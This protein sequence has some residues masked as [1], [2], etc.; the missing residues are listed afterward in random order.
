MART[1]SGIVLILVA[2]VLGLLYL[3]EGGGTPQSVRMRGRVMLAAMAAQGIV[4][5]AQYWSHLP[6]SLV[7]VHVF[8]A[9]VVWSAMYWFAN[10]LW[11]HTPEAVPVG[12]GSGPRPATSELGVE[13]ANA[14]MPG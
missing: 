12:A 5:Y 4:G 13:P 9:T 3:L 2:V 11:L 6:A 10:G 8:G 14:V 1:H 7:G